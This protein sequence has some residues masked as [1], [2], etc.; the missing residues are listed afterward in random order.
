[1]KLRLIAF[2]LLCTFSVA[3]TH[4]GT[5]GAGQTVWF[6]TSTSGGAPLTGPD[7]YC[8]PAGSGELT[9]SVPTWPSN[10]GPAVAPTTCLNTAMSS[11]PVGTHIG[12]GG[13]TTFTPANTGALNTALASLACG[14]TITLTNGVV[15]GG[16]FTLPNLACD[17]AHWIIIQSQGVS[18]VSFPAYG[19]LAKPNLIGIRNDAT[20]RQMPGYPDYVSASLTVLMAQVQNG[21]GGAGQ[22]AF[23][24]VSG[25]NHY[26]FIGLEITKN[27]IVNASQLVS[28]AVDNNSLGT[29]DIIFDRCILHG[30]QWTTAATNN[31]SVTQAINAGGS[32]YISLVG[33]FIYDVYCISSCIDSQAFAA[34]TNINQDGNFK[35]YNLFLATSGES[36][37]FGGG[38]VGAG[39]PNTDQVELRF[40]WSF[41]PLTW[42][43]PIETC[44]TLNAVVPKN[45]GEFKN[46][47]HFFG[48][49]IIVENSWQGCQADQIGY[50]LLANPSSQN[51]HASLNVDYNGTDIVTING[52]GSF[53][54]DNG[55]AD[56]ATYCP[57][58]GCILED[59]SVTNVVTIRRFC[60]HDGSNTCDQNGVPNRKCGG[61]GA[62]CSSDATCGGLTCSPTTTARL[63]AAVTAGT[64]KAVNAC[65]PGD[66]PTAKVENVIYRYVEMFNLT[67]GI[68]INSGTSSHCHDESRGLSKLYF[69]DIL[70][71]GLSLELSNGSDPYASSE[72]VSIAT[73]NEGVTA[74]TIELSH[75]TI[76]IE[77]GNNAGNGGL[78]D[79]T[80]HTNRHYM[81]GINIHD[82]VSPE[83]WNINSG[84]GSRVL[85]GLD[86]SFQTQS[87]KAYY[88]I[89]A[90]NGTVGSELQNFTFTPTLSSYIVTLNGKVI[91]LLPGFTSTAF[92]LAG[93]A[94][95]GDDITVRDLNTCDW[96]FLNILGTGLAGSGVSNAP[97][98]NPNSC[99]TTG[100]SSC[101]LAGS[102]FTSIFSNY[103]TGRGIPSDFVIVGSPYVNSASDK[104]TRLPTGQ[105]PGADLTTLAAVTAGLRFGTVFVPTLTITPTTLTT[106]AVNTLYQADLA[107]TGGASLY[108]GWFLQ[109]N[110]G[111]CGGSC[112]TLPAGVIVGRS[113]TV[114]GPF[115]V[116]T[117]SIKN[118]SGKAIL[119][120]TLVAG[121]NSWT[122]GQSMSF[123][124]FCTDGSNPCTDTAALDA[125]FN[126]TWAVIANNTDCTNS[127]TTV[128]FAITHA[129]VTGHAP[130]VKGTNNPVF[131]LFPNTTGV[132]T[133]WMGVRDGAFNTDSKAIHL[134][135]F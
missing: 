28:M 40:V 76:A 41:K 81:S 21:S 113:G 83:P 17:G 117:I 25:A 125:D 100:T 75:I 119:K 59:V 98:P 55:V 43:V 1:M 116:Q 130:S 57:P 31:D 8:P 87:C 35:L 15:Y 129:D 121:A 37:L 60:A 102:A 39:M 86:T 91:G 50:G 103:G 51:N 66:D 44:T 62:T 126:G 12:G 20:L 73:N 123:A 80:D 122:A 120:Q 38:G 67:N 16:S 36:W 52:A 128:C 48:E 58:G 105:S 26:R 22:A 4:I 23:E 90:P 11:T 30:P 118:N 114:N 127:I 18:N 63:T 135:V 9:H 79:Q 24:F 49:A 3:Q 27:P 71:H 45:D 84:K 47:V 107:A 110:T 109:T 96:R 72:G 10:V 53:A 77:T 34:G 7:A 89:E 112:G 68:E 133:F 29:H 124:G 2:C 32:R 134:T 97:Y 6:G 131:N 19:Q 65:V 78:G 69:G 95:S 101:I 132:F 5:G 93:A 46:V 111:V 92:S 74:N 70:M 64:N 85:G 106:V 56:D 33:D 88:P 14:D 61:T 82:V 94:S 115:Q 104:L 54:H 42:M 99:G 108:Q 13:A